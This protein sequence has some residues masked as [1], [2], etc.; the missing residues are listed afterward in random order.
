MGPHKRMAVSLN[1]KFMVLTT[2]EM[3]FMPSV[4]N[5]I[6]LVHAGGRVM[7]GVGYFAGCFVALVL[8]SH[9]NTG[10][11][12]FDFLKQFFVTPISFYSL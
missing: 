3:S 8:N 11:A 10:T 4:E 12:F 9:I 6:P 7:D 2:W 1:F 5:T